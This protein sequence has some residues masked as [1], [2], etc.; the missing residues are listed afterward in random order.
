[1]RLAPVIGQIK[2]RVGR[3]DPRAAVIAGL[4]SSV[5]YALVMEVDRKLTGSRVDD[6]ILVG[7]P[8][9][10]RRPDLARR[11]GA[12]VHLANGTSLALAYAAFGHH[13]LPGPA[14]VRGAIFLNLENLALYPVM[15]L[16]RYHPAVRDGQLQS[17]WS[18]PSFAESV[19]PHVVYGLCV[20]PLYEALRRD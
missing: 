9:V 15:A 10:P 8:F 16:D 6:L 1:M 17:Y 13:A 7:R 20:G 12:V 19:P 11:V 14:W 18:W 5:A 3:V 4:V 2:G